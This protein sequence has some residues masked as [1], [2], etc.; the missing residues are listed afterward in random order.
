MSDPTGTAVLRRSFQAEGNRRINSLRSLTH[1]M[2]VEH[3]LMK[4]RNDPLAAMLPH[5][6]YHLPAFTEWFGRMVSENMLGQN[7]WE[8]FLQR[9]YQS[10]VVTGGKLTRS[11]PPHS[12]APVPAVYRELAAREFAGIA[13]AVVQQVT[14]HAAAAALAKRR[15][16]PLYQRVLPVLKKV[17]GAR[18]KLAANSMTVQLHNAG[19]LAQFRAAGVRRVSVDAERLEPARPSRFLLQYIKHDHAHVHDQDEEEELMEVVTAGDDK[20]CIVCEEI[21]MGGPYALDLAE[22]LIPAH[23]NCRCAL[24]PAG[25]FT[26]EERLG[27]D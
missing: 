9:A 10:G 26:E 18:I 2:L 7:W 5:P 13:G 6:G 24:V 3:D 4:A 19:R 17:G 15:P 25:V 23:P 14:R 20:V 12:P 21:A 11:S 1:R 16:L 8:K 22:A 27:E